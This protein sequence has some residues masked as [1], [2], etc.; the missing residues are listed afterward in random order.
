MG[1]FDKYKQAVSGHGEQYLLLSFILLSLFA[2]FEA[3]QYSR[4]SAQFPKL[5]SLIIIIGS[6]YALF[7][8]VRPKSG[9]EIA[10]GTPGRT[11]AE[12]I[13]SLVF[14]LLLAF[15]I[16]SG[17]FIGLMWASPIFALIFGLWRE[18]NKHYIVILVVFFILVGYIFTVYMGIGLE[19]GVVK[20]I[21]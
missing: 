6:I 11:S 19:N 20:V 10:S 14:S 1:I 12:L 16:L 17:Y 13:D 2:Y 5:V 3:E 8:T 7:I 4:S 9:Q 15:Y 21:S 18:L